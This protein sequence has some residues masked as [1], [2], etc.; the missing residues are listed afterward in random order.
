MKRQKVFGKVAQKVRTIT[1]RDPTGV[2][3]PASVQTLESGIF[4]REPDTAYGQPNRGISF[5]KILKI[6]TS[7]IATLGSGTGK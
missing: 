3:G 2:A 5:L 1:R 4:Q 7:R 6:A